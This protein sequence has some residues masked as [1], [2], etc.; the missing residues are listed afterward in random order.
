MPRGCAPRG[1]ELGV[2][3]SYR[4]SWRRCLFYDARARERFL[5]CHAPG[6]CRGAGA[7]DLAAGGHSTPIGSALFTGRGFPAA[8]ATPRASRAGSAP[9]LLAAA[10]P[11]ARHAWPSGHRLGGDGQRLGDLA[12]GQQPVVHR[13]PSSNST[14]PGNIC[15]ARAMK[16]SAS[17]LSQASSAGL[18]FRSS[19]RACVGYRPPAACRLWPQVELARLAERPVGVGHLDVPVDRRVGVVFAAAV[20]GHHDTPDPLP[21][22]RVDVTGCSGVPNVGLRIQPGLWLSGTD[23]RSV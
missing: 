12:R 15:L 23:G 16:S 14:L 13:S 18:V 7:L 9:P 4:P 19:S 22:W 17:A 6:R 1:A 21:A 8:R 5:P 2:G 3:R 10:P 11:A 20:T